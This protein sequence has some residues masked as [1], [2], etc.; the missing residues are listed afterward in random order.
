MFERIF[1]EL[2]TVQVDPPT[3]K[4]GGDIKA[5]NALQWMFNGDF[6]TLLVS[7]AIVSSLVCGLMMIFSSDPKTIDG[8]KKGLINSV[9]ALVVYV[10]LKKFLYG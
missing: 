9:L 2:I 8:A 1:F 6:Y 10:T 4:P 5:N 7:A 3:G